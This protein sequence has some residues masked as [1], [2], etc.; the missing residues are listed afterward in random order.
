[1]AK[2]DS[3]S[4]DINKI[5]TLENEIKD[6]MDEKKVL[7]DKKKSTN[8]IDHMLKGR[9][10]TFRVEL[11]KL[12]S[13]VNHASADPTKFNISQKEADK[14]VSKVEEYIEKLQIIEAQ[15]SLSPGSAVSNIN[16]S[17]A[18]QDLEENL[19]GDDGEYMNTRGKNNKQVLN[20]QKDMLKKQ[21]E[22][23]DQLSAIAHNMTEDGKMIGE[24]LDHQN[25]MLDDLNRG[26]D[27][28][29]MKM[30]RVDGKLKKLIAESSQ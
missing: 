29:N 18:S 17:N 13:T 20:T 21:D 2:F 19:L 23:F 16:S 7:F 5:V 27:K 1:M 14:R 3:Y 24:E 25:N 26:M 22:H 11:E 8:K 9:V 10:D 4:R 6:L 28:T 30:I 12:H 15:I